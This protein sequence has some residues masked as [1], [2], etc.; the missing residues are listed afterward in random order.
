MKI[1]VD[2]RP[3]CMALHPKDSLLCEL[4]AGHTGRHLA[5][6]VRN[7]QMG[8]EIRWNQKETPAT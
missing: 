5:I 3:M 6:D 4:P 7:T 8:E 1:A 2:D